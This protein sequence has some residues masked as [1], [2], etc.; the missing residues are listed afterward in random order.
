M[1]SDHYKK[2]F[3]LIDKKNENIR[4][5]KFLSINFNQLSFQKIQKFIR[6][7][8]FKVN[9]KKKNQIINYS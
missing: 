9:G 4:L 8:L 6:T 3:C 5:D 7:G 1:V 2:N